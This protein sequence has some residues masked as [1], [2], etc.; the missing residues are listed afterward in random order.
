M[1]LEG[2]TAIVYGGG[3]AL[4]GAAARAFARAGAQVFLAGRSAPR[5][6]AVARDIA[7]AGGSAHWDTVDALDAAAVEQHAARVAGRAPGIH[8]AFNAIGVVHVQGVP[9]EGLSLDDFALPVD[10]Y[11]RSSFNIAKAVAPHMVRQRRGVVLS[12]TTPA[13]RMVGPGFL[14]HSVACAGVEAFSRHLAGELGASD[15]RSVCVR[16]HAIPQTLPLGSHAGPVFATEARRLGLT[17]DQML[18]GAATTT[19]LKR[20][21]TLDDLTAT[22]VFLASD[23]AAAISGVVV[24]MSGLVLD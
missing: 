16:S 20:L 8:I 7:A 14:G 1:V 12:L 21:P 15:V 4:G 19:L 17:V 3:G 13:S 24:N 23:G 18:E 5:L 2:R 9:L 22:L 11:I 10:T 6:E